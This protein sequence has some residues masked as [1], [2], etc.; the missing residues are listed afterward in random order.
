[1]KTREEHDLNCLLFAHVAMKPAYPKTFHYT[2]DGVFMLSGKHV[3]YPEKFR[4][5]DL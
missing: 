3:G 4:P 2:G 5:E 1:L